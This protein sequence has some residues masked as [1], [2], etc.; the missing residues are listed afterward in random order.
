M[1]AI[2]VLGS[3]RLKRAVVAGQYH[4]PEDLFYGGLG[5]G[6]ALGARVRARVKG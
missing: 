2:G 6:L 5:F 3:I 4:R 1:Y